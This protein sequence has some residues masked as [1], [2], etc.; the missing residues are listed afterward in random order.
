MVATAALSLAGQEWRSLAGGLAL[1][2]ILTAIVQ[3]LSSSSGIPIMLLALAVGISVRAL[4]AD[5]IKS[6]ERGVAF[7]AKSI[8]RMGV[9]LL[10]FRVVASDVMSLGWSSLLIILGTLVATLVGGYAIARLAGQP[11]DFSAVSATSV[12]VCGASAALAASSVVPKRDGLEHETIMVVLIVSL[13]STAV[14][15]AYPLLARLFAFD[16]QATALLLGGAIHDVA[17]VAGAGFAVSPLVGVN[18][19]TVKMVRVACLLP[20]IVAIGA[21]L[22]RRHV[23]GGDRSPKTN[24]MPVFLIAFLIIALLANSGL[25]PQ[26]LIALGSDVSGLALTASV[27]ALGLKT[28]LSEMKHVQP[29]L[30]WILVAQSCW[31]FGVIITLIFLIH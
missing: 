13:L 1:C 12:G 22:T 23:S 9:A 3:Y 19:V 20:V 29:R 30:I 8:L 27:V 28:S 11:S 4:V 18:A 24:L 15:I 26:R 21:M 16:P 10:G 6:F 2:V 25:L 14:M 31:Q 7:G 5:G 17:Q